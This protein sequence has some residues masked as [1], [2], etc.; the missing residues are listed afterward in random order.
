MKPLFAR[1]W[2]LSISIFYLTACG[3]GGGDN[4]AG[5]AGGAVSVNSITGF[6]ATG[7]PV[8]DSV[9]TATNGAVVVTARSDA[10]GRFTL[11]NISQFTFPLQI[12]ATNPA[13]PDVELRTVVLQ[14]QRIANITPAT[15]ALTKVLDSGQITATEIVRLSRVLQNALANYIL[16]PAAVNFFSDA[17]FRPDST[18]ID[19]VFDLVQID[20]DGAALVLT[21]KPNPT[22]QVSVSPAQ[23]NGPVLQRP[24]ESESVS[25][26]ALAAL[27]Q[28]FDNAFRTGNL[29]E[30]NLRNVMHTD[31]QDDQGY[32][33]SSFAQ[34]YN[35]PSLVSVSGFEILRCF[36]D[37]ATLFDRCQ[38]R[39]GFS[40]P[41]T[42]FAEDF[43]NSNFTQVIRR[44]FY[45]LEVERR[46]S[47]L[48]P[49]KLSGG[50]FKPFAAKVKRIDRL[51]QVVGANGF[52]APASTVQSG[53]FIQAPVTPFGMQPVGFAELV[54]SNL[55][56]AELVQ[57]AP[58][59]GTTG[60]FSVSKAAE[61]QCAAT[62]NL[63]VVQPDPMAAE[64]ANCTNVGFGNFVNGLTANSRAGEVFMDLTQRFGELNFVNRSRPVR[65]D[66]SA[67]V[68]T[69]DFPVLSNESLANLFEYASTPMLRSVVITLV[70][71]PNRQSVC[72]STG[73][74]P[75]PIC[76]YGQRRLSLSPDQIGK[77]GAYLVSSEDSFG[78]VIQRQYQFNIF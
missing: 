71:P 13:R 17:A 31:F 12:T 70:T 67:A 22:L 27:V 40:R 33:V 54:N 8:R 34:V 48:N 68:N 72:I 1:V 14:G 52:P 55:V 7:A 25:P 49:L 39:L 26:S 66:S 78:N 76:V 32:R 21:S 2:I 37:T 69:S 19:A 75:E 53:A 58:G 16:S 20:F 73:L 23:A 77:A 38:I 18:G 9:I 61:G 42:R 28:T 6:V 65:I 60:L 46:D 4:G 63:L 5:A 74:E 56:K 64:G 3:G 15:T 45:D 11:N 36:A 62:T 10:S 47:Q 50:Y 24:L 41:L 43:G 29:S 59:S 51:D 57:S 35:N 30:T 44:E